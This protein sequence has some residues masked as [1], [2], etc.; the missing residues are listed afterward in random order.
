MKLP[1]KTKTF[2]RGFT[3]IELLIVVVIIGILAAILVATINPARQQ[4]KARDAGIKASLNKMAL[5]VKSSISA[6]GNEPDPEAFVKALSGYTIFA[7]C[8][9]A[10][11]TCTFSL[12]NVTLPTDALVSGNACSV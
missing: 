10:G 6:Y 2:Q 1:D 8:T 5:S 12:N 9:T 4:N 3:L 7:G 11:V